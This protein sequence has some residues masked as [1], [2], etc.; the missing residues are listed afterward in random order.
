[1]SSPCGRKG[2]NEALVE[3]C[4]RQSPKRDLVDCQYWA[5]SKK[6]YN[7]AYTSEAQ[8]AMSGTIGGNR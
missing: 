7:G 2:A 4:R 1:M 8:Q 3:R 5:L 6:Q